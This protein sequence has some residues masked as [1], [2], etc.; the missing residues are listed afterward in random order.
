MLQQSPL[1][2]VVA[3]NTHPGLGQV[4]GAPATSHGLV[5]FRL[6]LLELHKGGVEASLVLALSLLVHGWLVNVPKVA[7]NVVGTRVPLSAHPLHSLII[8]RDVLK[9]SGDN[10]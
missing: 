9:A 3:I 10:Q 8:L 4:A 6:V 2:G 1:V 5:A 7:A